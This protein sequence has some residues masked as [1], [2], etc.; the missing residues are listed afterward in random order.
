METT[1][2]L[3][4]RCGRRE[5]RLIQ[6]VEPGDPRLQELPKLRPGWREGR[7]ARHRPS[8]LAGVAAPC[9]SRPALGS[10]PV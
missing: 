1:V 4:S 8:P 5:R 6:L 2:A 7:F 3:S 9:A 10:T